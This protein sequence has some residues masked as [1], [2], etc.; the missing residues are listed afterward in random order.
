MNIELVNNIRIV[1]F[2]TSCLE[3]KYLASF[4]TRNF[5]ISEA[6]AH[7]IGIVKSSETPGEVAAKLSAA[8]NQ[9]YTEEHVISL[10]EKCIAPILVEQE[11][12]PKGMF[13]WKTELIS[14]EVVE[15]FLKGLKLLFK[16]V[17]M[18]IMLFVIFSCEIVF[19]SSDLNISIGYVDVFVIVGILLLFVSSSFFHELGHASACRYYGAEQQG[20]GFGLYLNFPAFYTNVSDVWKL[21]R[22]QRMVVNFAGIYFQSIFLLPFFLIYFI[23][24]D[25]IVKYFIFTVNFNFLFTLNPFFKF[26]GYWIM[27]DMLGVGNLRT[28]STEFLGF[29]K[30]KILRKKTGKKPF[31]M[32]IKGPERVVL[33]IYSVVVNLFFLY[34][35]GY[36][37]PR[38]LK[39]F[40]INFPVLFRSLVHEIATGSTPSLQLVT[41]FIG[42]LLI[43]VLMVYCIY[44]MLLP[45]I[46]KGIN[47]LKVRKNNV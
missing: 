4:G 5:E 28:R 3:K 26:D 20:I 12:K 7:F 21:S 19:F 1:P 10:Y 39:Y 8:K 41:S 16:P 33:I 11:S 47:T 36:V 34:Y 13:L 18:V 43:F 46:K 42:Q 23:T 32:T 15:I 14:P 30:N 44:K 45:L 22:K 31:L 24:G 6:L 17:I 38:F 9:E 25:S 2:D 40:I 27:T 35:L 37:L 29:V